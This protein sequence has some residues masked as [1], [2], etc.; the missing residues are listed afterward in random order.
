M[1]RPITEEEI[2]RI[3]GS[4]VGGVVL[5]TSLGGPL[6]AV[7]GGVFGLITASKVNDSKRK[8]NGGAVGGETV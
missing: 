3:V 5:G 2:T 1:K 7:A 6:G 4:A 8:M